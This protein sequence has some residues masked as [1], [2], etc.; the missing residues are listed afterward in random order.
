MAARVPSQRYSMASSQLIASC[1]SEFVCSREYLCEANE[2]IPFAEL[3]GLLKSMYALES[4]ADAAD[5]ISA[6]RLMSQLKTFVGRS[7]AGLDTSKGCPMPI[8]IDVVNHFT[9]A[10]LTPEDMRR[11]AANAADAS[12]QRTKCLIGNYVSACVF[13]SGL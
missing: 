10:S 1:L 6:P 5:S 11:I 3:D 13:R 7:A 9:S 4:D 12:K 2:H 8:V